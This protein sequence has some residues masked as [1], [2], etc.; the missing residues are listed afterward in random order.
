MRVVAGKL[1]PGNLIEMR[2][3]ELFRLYY[4]DENEPVVIFTKELL[5]VIYNDDVDRNYDEIIHFYKERDYV[6]IVFGFL[7]MLEH[8]LLNSS[9]P[10]VVNIVFKGYKSNTET[11]VDVIFLITK[12]KP[13]HE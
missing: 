6:S 9:T 13:D 12:Y 10:N 3:I 4:T 11:D 2:L 8:L 5:K 1:L 7:N